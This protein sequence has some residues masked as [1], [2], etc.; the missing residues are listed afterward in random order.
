LTDWLRT[1]CD[2]ATSETCDI[3]ETDA[4]DFAAAPL[5]FVAQLPASPDNDTADKPIATMLDLLAVGPKFT[6]PASR[7]AAAAVGRYLLRASARPQ[8]QTCRRRLSLPLS[9][10]VT[11]RRSDRQ[12]VCAVLTHPV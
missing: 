3:E 2:R 8:Q 4:A 12:T 6:R 11:D 10:D 5:A 9:I 1:S 7:A